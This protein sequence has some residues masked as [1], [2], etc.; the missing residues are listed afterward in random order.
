MKNKIA[1]IIFN[2]ERKYDSILHSFPKAAVT[3]YYKLGGLQQQKF[4]LSQF[5]KSEPA[6][7]ESARHYSF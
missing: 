3:Y 7:S 4:I 6:A 1:H 5:W 2:G